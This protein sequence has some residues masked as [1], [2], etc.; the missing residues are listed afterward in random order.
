MVYFLTGVC[1]PVVDFIRNEV[2]SPS[3]GFQYKDPAA[4]Q[5]T[6][7]EARAPSSG[8]VLEKQTGEE[9]SVTYDVNAPAAPRT[10]VEAFK[11]LIKGNVKTATIKIKKN[12]L[13]RNM[14]D[15]Y[16]NVHVNR[17]GTVFLP[18]SAFNNRNMLEVGIITV[19]PTDTYEP[20]AENYILTVE[21]YG[22]YSS[23]SKCIF[24]LRYC[25]ITV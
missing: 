7:D 20:A 12:D 16:E 5:H 6:S 18:P 9:A 25:F 3:S 14:P 19:I 21:L 1:S 15:T 4:K 11:L 23:Y 22:C 8:I 13:S 2:Y 10:S 24:N 17:D